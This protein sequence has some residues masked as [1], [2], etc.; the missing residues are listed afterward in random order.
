MSGLILAGDLYLDLLDAAGNRTGFLPAV[1]CTQFAIT[2]P[3]DLKQRVSR[4]KSTFGQ[5]L[6]TIGIKKPSTIDVTIDENTKEVFAM[7]LLGAISGLT[8]S[9]G[10]VASGSPEAIN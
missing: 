7:N 3:S 5:A 9:A 8:K 1:N 2:E 4:G 10:T 6:D